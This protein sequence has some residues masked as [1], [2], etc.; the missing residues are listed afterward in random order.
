M[1][2][3]RYLPQWIAAA[4]GAAGLRMKRPIPSESHAPRRA[5]MRVLA[6]L[7]GVPTVIWISAEPST[8]RGGPKRRNKSANRLN[9]GRIDWRVPF[10][11]PRRAEQRGR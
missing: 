3:C 6:A 8:C 4:A 9:L 7:T 1:Y 11:A 10:H 2:S 5:A